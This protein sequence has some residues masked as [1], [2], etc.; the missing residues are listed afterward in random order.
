VTT[1][2]IDPAIA[3]SVLREAL[4]PGLLLLPGH[5]DS[6]RARVQVMANGCQES[7]LT[8]RFQLTDELG[9]KGPARGLWQMER[10]TEASRGGVT[11]I[12]LHHDTN[13]PLRLVCRARD[14][15]FDPP[16]IWAAL[17]GDDVLA[18]ACARLLLWTDKLALP[19]I[20]DADGAWD[21]YQ[22]VW[23]PGKPHP[24]TWPDCYAAAVAAV[25]KPTTTPENDA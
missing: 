1:A 6:A 2:H 21:C 18:A 4:V 10:G 16:T 24:E 13:E 23:R 25:T 12:W 20:G 5:M 19:Q 14:V 17:E 9:G 3:A 8:A 22:R 15:G 7:R 11:G